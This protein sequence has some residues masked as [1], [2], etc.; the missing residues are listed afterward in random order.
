MARKLQS[1]DSNNVGSCQPDRRNRRSRAVSS[2]SVK[3]AREDTIFIRSSLVGDATL[4]NLYQST[5]ARTMTLV[6]TSF[7]ACSRSAPRKPCHSSLKRSGQGLV[8]MLMALVVVAIFSPEA[9]LDVDADAAPTR[10]VAHQ[11]A[12]RATRASCMWAAEDLCI[13]T[14]D[15]ALSGLTRLVSHGHFLCLPRP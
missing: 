5:A 14:Q 9:F 12:V 2:S 3:A 10:L 11:C 4:F 13:Q 1:L 7:Q 8:C 15:S 6:E